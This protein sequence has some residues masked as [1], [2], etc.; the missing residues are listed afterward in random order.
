VREGALEAE[1]LPHEA[2]VRIGLERREA[3]LV[4]VERRCRPCATER[5]EPP[6]DV[7]VRGEIFFACGGDDQHRQRIA[8]A[9][10]RLEER[11]RI[12]A[13]DDIVQDEHDRLAARDA[14]HE[15]A[16]GRVTIARAREALVPPLHDRREI[17]GVRTIAA[18]PAALFEPDREVPRERVSL[19]PARAQMTREHRAEP[20]GRT[21]LRTVCRDERDR[22]AELERRLDEPL[23][24]AGLAVPRRATHEHELG[25]PRLVNAHEPGPERITL[26]LAPRERNGA[27]AVEA[28]A[29]AE[30]LRPRGCDGDRAPVGDHRDARPERR[31]PRRDVRGGRWH[32]RER[33]CARAHVIR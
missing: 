17:L 4:S 33:G 8:H 26:G 5:L 32:L 27:Q 12:E 29:R 3:E 13:E 15:A 10:E 11:E 24:E 9:A 22:G 30:Q 6:R 16:Q 1:Q 7:G 31:S 25:A 18:R 21:P 23:G 19:E 2:R 28:E 20:I 14:A